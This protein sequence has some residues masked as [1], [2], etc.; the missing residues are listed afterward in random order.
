M[1]RQ[2]GDIELRWLRWVTTDWARNTGPYLQ[3]VGEAPLGGRVTSEVLLGA[4]RTDPALLAGRDFALVVQAI[5]GQRRADGALRSANRR[6]NPYRLHQVIEH[7]RV[8]HQNT[9]VPDPFGRGLWRGC[10]GGCQR[11]RGGEG[12][13]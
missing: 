4:G 10:G 13:P 3:P 9:E 6:N 2:F 8:N 1:P 5:S 7:G 11:G 12:S